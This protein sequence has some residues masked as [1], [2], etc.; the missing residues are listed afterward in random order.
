MQ[1]GENCSN[2]AKHIRRHRKKNS[3][4]RA[5]QATEISA[6]LALVSLF[7]EQPRDYQ[8]LKTTLVN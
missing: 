8:L 1:E 2:Y 4:A 7:T 5:D 6:P 3:V